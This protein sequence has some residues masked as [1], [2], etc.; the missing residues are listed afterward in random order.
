MADAHRPQYKCQPPC[1]G[2]AP[3]PIQV[4]LKNR[5]RCLQGVCVCFMPSN[6]SKAPN[7][8]PAV[9]ILLVS[10]HCSAAVSPAPPSPSF[11]VFQHAVGPAVTAVS[12][13][14]LQVSGYHLRERCQVRPADGIPT[15]HRSN[16][17]APHGHDACPGGSRQ[18]R[19]SGARTEGRHWRGLRMCQQCIITAGN[20]HALKC[21]DISFFPDD[22]GEGNRAEESGDSSTP[23]FSPRSDGH[24]AKRGAPRGN[25][26]STA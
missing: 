26:K 21:S 7:F 4:N 11:R 24:S 6:M 19:R 15:R 12:A 1:A 25:C 10:L 2:F 5:H 8:S 16:H 3:T 23:C 20:H 9:H 14:C 17:E 22:P 18:R 13:V